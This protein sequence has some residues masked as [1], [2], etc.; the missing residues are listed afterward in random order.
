MSTFRCLLFLLLLYCNVRT[1]S[2]FRYH[3]EFSDRGRTFTVYD[4]A[5]V[6]RKT[7]TRNESFRG[8]GNFPEKTSAR[9]FQKPSERVR[10]PRV[11]WNVLT[12]RE[13]VHNKVKSMVRPSLKTDIVARSPNMWGRGKTTNAVVRTLAVTICVASGDF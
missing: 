7:I 10:R 12:S 11:G 1:R 5:A 8:V 3:G 13:P 2:R 9:P 4:V 6:S